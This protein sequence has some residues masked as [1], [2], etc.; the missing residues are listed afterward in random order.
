LENGFADCK[1]LSLTTSPQI[2]TSADCVMSHNPEL[3]EI[4]DEA[5]QSKCLT[6]VNEATQSCL[7]PE[8]TASPHPRFLGLA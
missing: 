3:Q 7:V 2:G 5:K 8:A 6:L 1:I 4:L